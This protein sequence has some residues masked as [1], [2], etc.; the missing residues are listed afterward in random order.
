MSLICVC[1]I[2]KFTSVEKCAVGLVDSLGVTICS[3]FEFFEQFLEIFDAVLYNPKVFAI[4][5][6][7]KTTAFY[8]AFYMGAFNVLFSD[9]LFFPGFWWCSKGHAL[10]R[11]KI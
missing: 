9:L 8:N 7:L 5:A 11:R 3:K 2:E 10:V 6:N 4:L 1:G